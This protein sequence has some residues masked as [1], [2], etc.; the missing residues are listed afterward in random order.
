MVGAAAKMFVFFD[1]VETFSLSLF[2]KCFL[3]KRG[4]NVIEIE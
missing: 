1:L 3:L 4:S 2:F